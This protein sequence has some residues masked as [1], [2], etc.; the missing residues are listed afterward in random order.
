MP[1]A[2]CTASRFLRFLG[3]LNHL[4]ARTAINIFR[5][6]S[7]GEEHDA[8]QGEMRKQNAACK[9]SGGELHG[10]IVYPQ[11]KYDGIL[12]CGFWIAD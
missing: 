8:K 4:L 2:V 10:G 3:L 9:S 1:V 12:D 5:G 7:H 11:T 6:H